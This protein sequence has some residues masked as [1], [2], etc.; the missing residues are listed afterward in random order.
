MSRLFLMFYIKETRPREGEGWDGQSKIWFRQQNPPSPI[1]IF[2]Y[3]W[4]TPLT[5]S[6]LYV[7]TMLLASPK[8]AVRCIRTWKHACMHALSLSYTYV[9]MWKCL[10]T[11]HNISVTKTLTHYYLPAL[12]FNI[13]FKSEIITSVDY[14]SCLK[15]IL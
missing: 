7:R 10:V 11:T 6:I 2:F 4:W 14:W 15:F 1:H 5:T 13:L 12:R 8:V 3:L 9:L